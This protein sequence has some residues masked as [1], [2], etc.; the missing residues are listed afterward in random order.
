[1]NRSA[2]SAAV[3][4]VRSTYGQLISRGFDPA[5]AANLTALVNGIPVDMQPWTTTGI[6][7]LLF[8]RELSRAGQF[9]PTD[10]H[11]R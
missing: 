1:V 5:E 8:L 3:Q 11:N 4:P 7:H 6:S 2:R 9:G 10:G